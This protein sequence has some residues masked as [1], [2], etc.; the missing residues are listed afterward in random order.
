MT[1]GAGRVSTSRS[2]T[3]VQAEVR[4]EAASAAIRMI[5]FMDGAPLTETTEPTAVGKAEA[6]ADAR[7]RAIGVGFVGIRRGRVIAAAIAIAGGVRIVDAG[8]QAERGAADQQYGPD[9]S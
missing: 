5:R 4:K 9:S 1:V 6:Q 7:R 3:T 2:R 8:R